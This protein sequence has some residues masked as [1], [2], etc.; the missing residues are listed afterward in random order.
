MKAKDSFTITGF[1]ESKITERTK[2]ELEF[3]KLK[4]PFG[5]K[6]TGAKTHDNYEIVEFDNGVQAALRWFNYT[7]H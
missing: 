1:N 6:S 4:F 2:Q 3:T 7:K 5:A